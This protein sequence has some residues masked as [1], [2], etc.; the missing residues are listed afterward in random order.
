MIVVRT[1]IP[2][3][4]FTARVGNAGIAA[5]RNQYKAWQMIA[6][7]SRWTTPMDVKTSHPKASVLK[8][9]R[10]VFNIKGNSYRLVCQINYL[11]GTVEIRFFGS[12]A[13]YDSINA[14]TV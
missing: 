7:A 5:A 11:A 12:H 14:E 13:D 9:G 2:N 10:V 1:D 8:N 6:T 4:Y 3:A